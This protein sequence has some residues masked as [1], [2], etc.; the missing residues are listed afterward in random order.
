[1]SISG[2]SS[3][4]SSSHAAAAA[5]AALI[6]VGWRGVG[7]EDGGVKESMLISGFVE[8]GGGVPPSSVE[9]QFVLEIANPFFST[10][11]VWKRERGRGIKWLRPTY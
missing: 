10:P 3:S 1:M 9:G 6:S 5:A 11:A 8:A 4:S 2:I 7:G